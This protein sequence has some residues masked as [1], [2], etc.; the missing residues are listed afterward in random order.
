[1][2]V[3]LRPVRDDELASVGVLHH[4]SRAAAYAHLLPAESF[5]ARGPEALSAWWVERWRWEKDT[6]RMTVAEVGGEL[7][8]FTYVGP[9]ET[10]GA[11]ELYA[12]HVAPERVGTGIG[13]P[14]MVEALRQLAGFGA[15]RAVLWVLADNPVARRFYEKGGWTADGASRVEAI[16]DRPLRQLRYSY[17]RLAVA[18]VSAPTRQP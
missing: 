2:T 6:H 16:N 4:R 7:A 12:I 17:P 3:L 5:A 10:P 18:A 11:A 15:D 8:G 13:R 9:S 1:M 14:L